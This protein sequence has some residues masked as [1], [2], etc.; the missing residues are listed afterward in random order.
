MS[1]LLSD[2][3]Y[4]QIGTRYDST[5]R[6]DSEIVARLYS[7][8]DRPGVQL[9][10]ACGSG[11]YTTA[12]A[13]RGLEMVG[14][15]PSEKMLEQAKVKSQ[16]IK[17]VLGSAERLPFP[18]GLFSGVV[19][20][21]AVYL[22]PNLDPI[23]EEVERVMK[24]GRFVLFTY[25]PEQIRNF[26]L[27]EYFPITL[28]R[29]AESMP[30][31][32]KLTSALRSAG[33]EKVSRENYFVSATVEDRFLSSGKHHPDWYL[34]DEFRSGISAF[35]T[36]GDQEEIKKGCLRLKNDIETGRVKQVLESASD[37]EGDATFLVAEK[38]LKWE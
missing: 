17:W 19:C 37:L 18:D 25:L 12:L 15:D 28:D 3:L 7:F 34:S 32:P 20:T 27:T 14:L 36:L 35:V 33:F 22:F 13:Q 10:L 5:R 24:S 30:S 4:N 21:F 6:A 1:E 38:S 31:L 11:N 26:W 23:F 2:P 9:D 8:L 29:V 16:D